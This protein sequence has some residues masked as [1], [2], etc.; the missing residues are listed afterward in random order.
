MNKLIVV[1]AGGHARTVISTINELKLW[2][3]YGVVDVN[4]SGQK[5]TILGVDVLGG[6]TI[7]DLF[8]DSD[9]GIVVALGDNYQ[10]QVLME[11]YSRRGFML[12][13]IIH[14]SAILD[15]TS[16]IADGNY[17]GAMAHVGPCVSVGRGNIIN[18][19]TNIE[20]ETTIGDYNHIA[21][22]AVLC[23]R[24]SIENQV[25]VGANATVLDKRYIANNTTIG[26]GAVAVESINVPG[27]KVVGIPGREL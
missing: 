12:P 25:L 13:N 21:P 17:V 4:F 2:D 5:E 1:G 18:T 11:N 27:K 24:V 8:T 19:Q 7:I 26:A 20:H 3:I 16:S 10:R 6:V 14:P 15:K 23:G 9:M 22:S